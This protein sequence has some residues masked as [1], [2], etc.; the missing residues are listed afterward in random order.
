MSPPKYIYY[1]ET[2]TWPHGRINKKV[3]Q[4]FAGWQYD[5]IP[6]SNLQRWLH[7]FTSESDAYWEDRL[8]LKEKHIEA[9][10]HNWERAIRDRTMRFIFI[11]REDAEP[12]TPELRG[13][14][15]MLGFAA[16]MVRDFSKDPELGTDR[17]RELYLDLDWTPDAETTRNSAL[18]TPTYYNWER[19]R[20]I[21]SRILEFARKHFGDDIYPVWQLLLYGL[22]NRVPWDVQEASLRRLLEDSALLW[23]HPRSRVFALVETEDLELF[24]SVGFRRGDIDDFVVLDREN[25]YEHFSAPMAF[26]ILEPKAYRKGKNRFIPLSTEPEDEAASA[27]GS[28]EMEESGDTDESA[29]TDDLA[30]YDA[31]DY[32]E[33]PQTG[34]GAE[35]RDLVLNRGNRGRRERNGDTKGDIESRGLGSANV[36]I[37]IVRDIDRIGVI[38]TR[39]RYEASIAK[40]HQRGAARYV[41]GWH[42]SGLWDEVE[43]TDEENN[44]LVAE[45]REAY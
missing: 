44:I 8:P 41:G 17:E 26:L 38:H 14:N 9:I 12:E 28:E 13:E 40:R 11:T 22:E 15:K 6:D 43:A 24:L 30:F 33:W 42:L 35:C 32:I 19:N 31:K 1:T 10:A 18:A 16:W 21:R 2:A 3:L 23:K 39:R 34:A 7:S 37:V 4:A 5:R 45:G 25:D 20:K 27:A 29:D 36:R